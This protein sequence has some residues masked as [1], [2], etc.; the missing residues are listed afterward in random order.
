MTNGTRRRGRK[1]N[2]YIKQIFVGRRKEGRGLCLAS[3]ISRNSSSEAKVQYSTTPL[4][5]SSLLSIVVSS[6][7][8]ESPLF[9]CFFFCS[10][11]SSPF[12]LL[13]FLPI[14]NQIV[15]AGDESQALTHTH[16][17]LHPSIHSIKRINNEPPTVCIICS[18]GRSVGR[19]GAINNLVVTRKCQPQLRVSSYKQQIGRR[20]THQSFVILFYIA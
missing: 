15:V 2:K 5:V 16:K 11:S 9:P 1:T 14:D 13:F 18:F 8:H 17:L 4:N 6:P 12:F 20:N 19:S 7:I 3:S 10:S